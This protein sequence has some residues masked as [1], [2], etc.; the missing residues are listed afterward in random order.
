MVLVYRTL[1][2][3]SRP[4]VEPCVCRNYPSDHAVDF[5][6][7]PSNKTIAL[8]YCPSMMYIYLFLHVFR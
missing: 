7:S 5:R 6:D 4:E 8:V 1:T 2:C 3:G